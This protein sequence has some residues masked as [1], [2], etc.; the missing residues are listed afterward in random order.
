MSLRLDVRT[1]LRSL[2]LTR[3]SLFLA[4]STTSSMGRASTARP[5]G[6]LLPMPQRCDPEGPGQQAPLRR[7][8]TTSRIFLRANSSSG[9]RYRTLNAAHRDMDNG[10]IAVDVEASAANFPGGCH[11]AVHVGRL[12]QHLDSE[13]AGMP[14]ILQNVCSAALRLTCGTGYC[15]T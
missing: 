13:S 1:R 14:Q 2:L 3:T 5:N 8:N 4:S 10:A 11:H 9:R 15:W 7:K 6:G 12:W